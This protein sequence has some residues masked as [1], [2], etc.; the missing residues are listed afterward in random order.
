[1]SSK[2]KIASCRKNGL[3]AKGSK[4]PESLQKSALNSLKHG[5]CASALHAMVLPTEDPELFRQLE[6]SYMRRYR[7][8][9]ECERQILLQIVYTVWRMRR[10]PSIETTLLHAEIL[11]I[12]DP[13][14][15]N[16]GFTDMSESFKIGRAFKNLANDDRSFDLLGRYEGRLHRSLKSLTQDLDRLKSTRPEAPEEKNPSQPNPISE[17][18]FNPPPQPPTTQLPRIAIDK[19]MLLS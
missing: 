8:Q 6:E 17:Q 14:A 9:D 3:K 4:S 11:K 19:T 16:D 2:R 15:V 5:L 10:I 7:P 13:N 12:N 18:P 1:M